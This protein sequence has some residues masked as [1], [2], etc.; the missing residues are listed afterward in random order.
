MHGSF[1]FHDFFGIA[2]NFILNSLEL[3]YENLAKLTRLSEW[4]CQNQK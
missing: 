4:E 2:I 1:Y 3:L